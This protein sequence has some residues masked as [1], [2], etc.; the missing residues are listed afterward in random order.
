M[1]GGWCPG[2]TIFLAGLQ[3]VFHAQERARAEAARGH[4][5]CGSRRGD[6]RSSH[7]KGE[8]GYLGAAQATQA[9][10]ELE[11]MRYGA[12]PRHWS[13]WVETRTS[14]GVAQLSRRD[15]LRTQAGS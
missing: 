8:L 10:R 2:R 15:S 5:G 13:V 9:A 14:C 6:G 3:T 12:K 7:I 11:D 1:E 4:R